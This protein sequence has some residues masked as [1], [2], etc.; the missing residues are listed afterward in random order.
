MMI[1]V[2]DSMGSGLEFQGGAVSVILHG[3]CPLGDKSC[4]RVVEGREGRRARAGERLETG[5][6]RVRLD[7]Y[8]NTAEGEETGRANEKS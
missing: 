4:S 7:G 6:K 2:N 1:V 3:L 5:W 8:G